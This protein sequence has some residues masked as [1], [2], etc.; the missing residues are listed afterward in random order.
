M[1]RISALAFA[2]ILLLATTAIAKENLVVHCSD[3][4]A[5]CQQLANALSTKYNVKLVNTA[6]QANSPAPNMVTTIQCPVCRNPVPIDTTELIQGKAFSCAIC[7]AVISLA[8]ESTSSARKAY[9]KFQ[10][11]KK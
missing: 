6:P 9:E 1:K 7:R 4:P 2:L 11:L 8:P 3:T 10:S 5:K